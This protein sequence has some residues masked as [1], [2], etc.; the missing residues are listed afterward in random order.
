M[1][2]KKVNILIISDG[3]AGIAL[4][5]KIKNNDSIEKIFIAPEPAFIS[6]FF[7]GVD[8]RD[9]DE[10]E[11]LKF[12][13]QNDIDLTVIASEK[14]IKADLASFFQANGQKVFAPSSQAAKLATNKIIGKKFLY[15]IHAQTSK[16]GVCD[17]PQQAAEWLDSANFP[18]LIRCS[19]NNKNSQDKLVSP[20]TE[21]ALGF[22]ENLFNRGE[23]SVLIEEYISG[24]S[25]T[26]YFITDGYSAI[27]LP[28][29]GN[30]KFEQDGESGLYTNGTGCFVPDYLISDT[31]ISRVK[32]IAEKILDNLDK[33]NHPYIGILGIE[34]T[35]TGEDKF[36]VNEIMPFLQ[37]YDAAAVLNTID[38]DLIKIFNACSE[39]LFADEYE[40]ITTNN[41]SSVC[42]K[43]KSKNPNPEIT[44]EDFDNITYDKQNI[45]ITEQ[46]SNITRAKEKLREILN[47]P[48]FNKMPFRR[49]IIRDFED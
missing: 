47:E 31:I 18:V 42:V 40:T 23:S 17:K 28:P 49:D 33:S 13:L 29:V 21:I 12:A 27:P 30:Y 44:E 24:H 32:N 16:F 3:A 34:C 10:N 8:I 48:R 9:D 7:E 14:A 37:D 36:Y 43:L 5:K 38:D 15:K 2:D 1:R 19:E 6:D 26:I 20:T 4:A 45:Y 11:L 22:T 39:G 41:Y 25:F 46:A 35:I